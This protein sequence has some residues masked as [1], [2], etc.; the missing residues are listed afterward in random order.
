MEPL[1]FD[2]ARR[3]LYGVYHPPAMLRTA[4]AGVVLCY[5]IGE[6]Y[7]RI[8]R[9]FR[10]LAERLAARG[11]HVLR[12]DYD[13]TGNSAG[14]LESTSFPA[15]Q[16]NVLS[17]VDELRSISGAEQLSLIGLRI[18]ALLAAA[19]AAAARCHSLVLWDPVPSG[20]AFRAQLEARVTNSGTPLSD[21]IDEQ[22]AINCAG[23][24]FTN[25]LLASG[26][27][28][29]LA[30]SHFSAAG[31]VLLIDPQPPI[32]ALPAADISVDLLHSD[33]PADWDTVD[34]LGGLFLPTA[35]LSS[36]VDWVNEHG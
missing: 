4:S 28:V 11:F 17:A 27:G 7:M 14:N 33:T 22:Q 25:A 23:Y 10:W 6:E 21:F 16:D 31:G 3:Q 20:S 19:S 24:R 26:Q 12:F 5:P 34:E 15:W 32:T 13:G 9:A 29:E 2:T 1:F 30:A 36:I 18:G 35:T 8:H